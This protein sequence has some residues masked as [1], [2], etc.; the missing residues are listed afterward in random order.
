MPSQFGSEILLKWLSPA[1]IHTPQIDLDG[2]PQPTSPSSPIPLYTNLSAWDWCPSANILFKIYISTP[3]PYALPLFPSY[4]L[5]L[6][7][8]VLHL[9]PLSPLSSLL[10]HFMIPMGEIPSILNHVECMFVVHTQS[11]WLL[12]KKTIDVFLEKIGMSL[13]QIYETVCSFCPIFGDGWLYEV[14]ADLVIR[15][16]YEKSC[17]WQASS[18]LCRLCHCRYVYMVQLSEG[19]G[20][21][22]HSPNWG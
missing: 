1:N 2:P 6:F 11:I 14:W 17:L 19:D 21:G 5:A 9:L 8:A 7:D 10:P 13:V 22:K 15:S 16:L 20:V 4:S 18:W 3:L 12:Q